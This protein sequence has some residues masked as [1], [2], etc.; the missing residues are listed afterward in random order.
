MHQPLSFLIRVVLLLSPLGPNAVHPLAQVSTIKTNTMELTMGKKVKKI[1]GRKIGR[2]VQSRVGV[3]QPDVRPTHGH[4]LV[5]R[6][7]NMLPPLAMA[8]TALLVLRLYADQLRLFH[9]TR[10]WPL[11]THDI[12]ILSLRI[13]LLLC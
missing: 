10:L 9:H 11:L 3:L 6:L 7:L 12:C 1:V 2:G 5:H 4:A 8:Q 13:L